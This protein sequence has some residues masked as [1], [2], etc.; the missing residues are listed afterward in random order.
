MKSISTLLMVFTASFLIACGETVANNST[1]NEVNVT[2]TAANT[3]ANAP[4]NKEE[5]PTVDKSK[6]ETPGDSIDYQ[7]ELVKKGDFETLKA[8]CF[9]DRVKASLTK[10]IVEQAQKD[11]EMTSIDQLFDS[12]EDGEA[13][14][15]KTA[16]IIMKS[17]R[18]LTTLIETDGKWLSDTIWFN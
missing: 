10:E 6:L 4:I 8:C 17:G 1:V 15:K 16:K 14:G 5:A 7:F 13:D 9:T 18:T 12:V 3:A 11:S 2:N